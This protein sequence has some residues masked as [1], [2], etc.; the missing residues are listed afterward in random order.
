MWRVV[1]ISG[2]NRHL[3]LARNALEVMEGEEKLGRLPLGDINAVIVHAY[4][5]TLST[6]LAAALAR[7]NIPLVL[8]DNKHMPSSIVWPFTGHFEQADRIATQATAT[9]GLIRRLWRHIIRAKIREQ[10][11]TLQGF[12][13]AGAEALFKLMSLVKPGDPDNIEA[14]AAR[15][16]WS[17]L[18]G[19][20]FIRHPDGGG[21]NGVLN[22]G[23]IVL[24][25]AM[26][27]AVAA[28][29]LAPALG[30]FHTSKRNPFRLVDD[31]MEPFRPL[32]DRVVYASRKDWGDEVTPEAKK[33]LAA[34]VNGAIP[35]AEGLLPVYRVMG[36]MAASLA[37]VYA[38]QRKQLEIP[39]RIRIEKQMEMEG[40]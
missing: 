20:D 14:R 3:R 13:P 40:L 16:Y 9:K 24:R 38:G 26:A 33:A 37:A 30:I 19:E 8:C 39:A 31:L 22:Y 25:S 4:R 28:A 27:R 12:D 1:D 29:G 11:H 15:F 23:Y 36:Q 7:E 32:V 18:L 35:T 2:E 21:A 17:R 10:A 6:D 34:I 5:A